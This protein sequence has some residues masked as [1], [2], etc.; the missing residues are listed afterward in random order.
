MRRIAVPG[1]S[2]TVYVASARLNRKFWGHLG[3]TKNSLTFL[4]IPKA[5]LHRK[6]PLFLYRC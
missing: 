5:R 2:G 4:S 6:I 3:G 1:R